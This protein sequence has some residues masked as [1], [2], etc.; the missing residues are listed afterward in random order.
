MRLSDL[1]IAAWNGLDAVFLLENR[2]N[3]EI[4]Y[5]TVVLEYQ[6]KSGD[7]LEAVV[8]E[9]AP[10]TRQPSNNFIPAE[11]VEPLP[12]P[13][14]P[15]Q[16]KQVSGRSPYTPCECPASARVTMLHIH[17]GDG[18]DLGWEASDWQT[19]PLLYDYPT[20][21]SIPDSN[22]WSANEY[23]FMATVNREG[24][25]V[26]VAPIPGTPVAPSET[27]ADG[28]K[29]LTF[30][31]G[32]DKGKPRTSNLILRVKFIRPGVVKTAP[33][34]TVQEPII[35]KPAVFISLYPRDSGEI[36]WS[37]DFGRGFGYTTTITHPRY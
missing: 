10:D 22:S 16:T 32:L 2:G 35:S 33:E 26:E 15:G 14:L 24:H 31:P 13:I 28:M 25:L 9:A 37:F 8:F 1:R 21:L 20:N 30:S 17:F 19:E 11:R 7:D 6:T 5:L 36:D 18:S 4:V 3:K 27:I 29:K 23:F 34:R 12:Q